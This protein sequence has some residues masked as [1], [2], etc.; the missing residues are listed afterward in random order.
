MPLTEVVSISDRQGFSSIQRFDGKTTIAVTADVDSQVVTATE[1]VA[2]LDRTLMPEVAS[3]YGIGY[4]FSG[5][6]E[7]RMDA[8]ADLRIGL[9]IALAAIYIILAWIFAS[10]PAPL[11]S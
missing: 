1:L 2:E 5:R 8:F 4:H 9:I 7:E 10:S 6:N 11:R 3:Q